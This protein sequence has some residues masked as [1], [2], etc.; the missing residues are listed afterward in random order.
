[1]DGL[2][3]IFGDPQTLQGLLSP[4]QINR[5]QRDALMQASM[6]LLR[7]SGPSLTPISTGQALADAY[8]AGRGAFGKGVE[9][10]VSNVLTA[11]K[12]KEAQRQQKLNDLLMTEQERFNKEMSGGAGSAEQALSA[13]VATAG[14]VGPTPERAAMINTAQTYDPKAYATGLRNLAKRIGFAA[15]DV[16][17]KYLKQANELD[18]PFE[19]AAKDTEMVDGKPQTVLYGKRGQRQE[20][21]RTPY[22]SPTSAMQE[23]EFAKSQGY[24]GSLTDFKTLIA[25][26]GATTITMPSESERTAGFLVQRLQGGLQSLAEAIGM[27]KS[28]A[29]PNMLGEAIQKF[30]GSETLKNLATPE[31][32]QKVEAA[33]LEILD[34]ALTLGTGAAYTREQLEGYR[35]SYFPQYGDKPEV[36]ADKQRRLNNLLSAARIKSG[37]STPTDLGLPAGVTV[38]RVK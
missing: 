17:E 37:R 9:S 23:Y 3:N 15:P 1:M 34:S 30:T 21:G 2:L 36:V 14:R 8:D 31:Q 12:I 6:S 13:P 35:R 29:S 5:A 27:D 22:Q 10:Q 11:Q 38:E 7:S 24:T 33:Q 16:A 4:E 25:R 28:A 26:S 32:R 19:Y 18:P 20:T